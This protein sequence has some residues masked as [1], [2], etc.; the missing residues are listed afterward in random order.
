MKAQ[1]FILLTALISFS[2]CAD[3][4]QMSAIE[5]V[6][7][8]GLGWNLGN[9][10]ECFGNWKTIS[11]PDDQIT[12]WGNVVPTERMVT[13]IQKYGFKTVRF[14]VTWMYFMD[15]S[16]NVRKDF[17]QRVKE[18]VD[19]I[20][21]SD[22][23]V[24]LNVHHDGVSGNWLSKG[25]SERMRFANL[26]TNIAKVFKDYDRRLIFESMNEVE[27]K[28]NDSYDYDTLK[29]LTQSFVDSVRA[30]GGNNANRLL[31]VSGANT[32]LDN[33]CSDKY[34][35][36]TD[37]ANMLAVDI[38]YYLPPQFT[39]ESDKNPWTWTDDEGIVHEITPMTTWGTEADYKE[40]VNN[41]ETM[42][43]AY[44]S[45]GIPVIL[46][47][48]GVLT[49]EKKEPDSIREFLTAEYCF[50][51]DYD[52]IMSILWD[53]SKNTAGDMNYYNRENDRWY[54]EKLQN[55]FY[56]ISLGKYPK[57]SDY[58]SSSNSETNSA[59]DSDGNLQINIGSKTVK[60]VIF[61]AKITGTTWQC[62]FGLGSADENNE[63]FGD[64]IGGGEG[65]YNKD[66]QTYTFTIDVAKM[67]KTP[68]N[69][70]QVQRWWGQDQITL[71]YVTVVYEEYAM[72]IDYEAYRKAINAM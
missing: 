23:Y 2:I 62:G 20:Y 61:N 58:Y 34:L 17:M 37:P 27:Y 21:Y 1:L 68:H 28:V 19:W 16:G 39:V 56:S 53:T 11:E 42:K 46:G 65:V 40:M 50:S 12:L 63:W 55:N 44:L 36:P 13:T 30:T 48:L 70:I 38:H 60:Q 22:M 10:F 31:L 32:N 41:F 66:D 15:G 7:D 4:S 26:W 49:E 9:T 67:S 8:M 29:L 5:L 47:E 57:P 64:S 24:I 59:V 43:K 3:R 35:L 45:K 69:Y 71:N 18:V 51:A 54:D 72:T 33:T 52:G 6:N 14:P 25:K